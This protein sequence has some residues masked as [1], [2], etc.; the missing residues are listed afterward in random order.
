[1]TQWKAVKDTIDAHKEA[2]EVQPVLSL[3]EEYHQ[4]NAQKKALEKR[5]E[6]I[7]AELKPAVQEVGTPDANGSYIVRDGHLQVKAEKRVSLKLKKNAL[8]LLTLEK[9]ELLPEVTKRVIDEDALAQAFHDEKITDDEL[10][11]LFDRKENYALFV[12]EID[13]E[14]KTEREKNFGKDAKK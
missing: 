1:M 10:E 8:D 7:K 13:D 4:L 6:E 12:E 3:A 14:G 11:A 9:P 2:Q 5:L